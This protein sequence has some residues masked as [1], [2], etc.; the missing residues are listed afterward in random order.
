MDVTAVLS[1]IAP[2]VSPIVSVVGLGIAYCALRTYRRNNLHSAQ[3]A[4][5]ANVF[6]ALDEFGWAAGAPTLGPNRQPLSDKEIRDNEQYRHVA[7][8]FF[9]LR[10]NLASIQVLM[11]ASF[12]EHEQEM[13]R[14]ADD[15]IDHFRKGHFDQMTPTFNR[16]T[17]AAE[18]L[19]KHCRK[20]VG[21]GD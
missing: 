6:Q 21:V 1:W 16:L 18:L 15:V 2:I 9:V 14:L 11:P 5:C 19:R 13:R 12:L 17:A 3:I 10:R 20:L 8:T 7:T 4:L